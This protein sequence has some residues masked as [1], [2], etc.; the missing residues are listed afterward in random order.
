MFW[1]VLVTSRPSLGSPS[2]SWR[3]ST[4]AAC[5]P[6]SARPLPRRS[7]GT[8]RSRGF[9]AYS[10]SPGTGALPRWKICAFRV[11]GRCERCYM[12]MPCESGIYIYTYVYNGDTISANH[13]FVWI[14][15]MFKDDK[16]KD[17]DCEKWSS[18]LSHERYMGHQARKHNQLDLSITWD[19]IPNSHRDG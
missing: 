15:P 7:S 16:W 4:G 14:S 18:I 17:S 12:T 10:T 9:G 13:I 11:M 6:S 2:G 8:S 1:Y 19:F 3:S 5:R